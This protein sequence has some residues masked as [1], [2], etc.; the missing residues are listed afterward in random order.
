[1]CIKSSIPC[2]SVTRINKLC[3]HGNIQSNIV[4]NKD[5]LDNKKTCL[6]GSGEM[7][8]KSRGIG[9]NIRDGNRVSE[10]GS[11][12][13]RRDYWMEACVYVLIS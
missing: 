3:N 10:I 2:S 9:W 1:M 4:H 12:R 5:W 7:F 6:P 11:Q 13:T 8:W